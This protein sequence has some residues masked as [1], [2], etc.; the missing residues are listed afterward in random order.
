[1]LN[2]M[3]TRAG[4]DAKFP[5]FE[6]EKRDKRTYLHSTAQY[7]YFYMIKERLF[8]DADKLSITGKYEIFDDVPILFMDGVKG[9]MQFYRDEWKKYVQSRDDCKWIDFD[10]GHWLMDA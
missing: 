10:C 4:K 3:L 7:L 9:G 6:L 8:G 1:M 2:G 5:L